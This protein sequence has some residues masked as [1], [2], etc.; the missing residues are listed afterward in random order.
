MRSRVSNSTSCNLREMDGCSGCVDLFSAVPFAEGC[1]H[2]LFLDARRRGSELTRFA[3][4]CHLPSCRDE[5]PWR[6]SWSFFGTA[7]FLPNTPRKVPGG[8]VGKGGNT[9]SS[10]M[11]SKG[12]R[13]SC[14]DA[15]LSL[16]SKLLRLHFSA[17][18]VCS[19]GPR[20]WTPIWKSSSEGRTV[21][22]IGVS[23]RL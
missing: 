4:R 22:T 14:P 6:A 23:L 5:Q 13:C 8:A 1:D 20:E 15:N 9:F 19:K 16:W 18:T 7:F 2:F 12:Q 10:V 21:S 17:E 3:L 11:E